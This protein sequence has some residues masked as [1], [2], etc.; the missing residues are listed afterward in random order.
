[1]HAGCRRVLERYVG[2]EP[3]LDG[4]EGESISVGA[5]LNTAAI[6]LVGNVTSRPP[7]TGRLLHRGWRITRVGLP[8]LGDTGGR[9]IVAQAEVEVAESR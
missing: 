2:F 1:V 3:I 8:P 9:A 7:L 5:D 4:R 6:R